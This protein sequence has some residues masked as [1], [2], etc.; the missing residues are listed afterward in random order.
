MMSE[1]PITD[2]EILKYAKNNARVLRFIKEVKE[3]ELWR[4]QKEK[5]KLES[6]KAD[7]VVAAAF[8]GATIK[9]S[10]ILQYRQGEYSDYCAT[11]VEL[12]T[13]KGVFRVDDP[14]YLSSNQ[15]V[16]EEES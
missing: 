14:R 3:N 7:E 15:K 12:V 11:V 4:L 9:E 8:I 5:E 1:L 6:R 16:I 13:D 10:K 2:E